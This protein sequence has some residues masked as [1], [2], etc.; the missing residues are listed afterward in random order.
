MIGLVDGNNF[1]VSCEQVFDPALAGKPV[2]VLS[3][4]DGCCISRSNEFKALGI[5]MGTPFFQLRPLIKKYG[6][7]FRS[8]NYE[9]Y[10]DMSRRMI[11]VLHEFV[12]DVEQ[13][14]I[15][16]AFIFPALSPEDDFFQFGSK[17]RQTLL[18]WTGIPSGVGFAATKTL[19]KIANHIG[20]K[21]PSGIFVM[22]GM[23]QKILEN[24]PVSEIWGVGRRLA[25][26][27]ERLGIRNAWQLACQDHTV[28]GK[29]F[30]SVLAKTILELQ[31]RPCFAISPDNE[32][33]QSISC[34][35]SFGK[36]VTEL[37]DLEESVAAYIAGAA[38]KLRREKQSASG[39]NV[40]FQLYPE[41]ISEPI[42]KQITSCT[43]T[44]TCATDDTSRMMS[45]VRPKLKDIFIPGRRYK[46]SGAVF[47]GL[48][49]NSDR[50]YDLFTPAA[51]QENSK[52]FK[53]VDMLNRKYGKGTVKIL[54]E[55]LTKPWQMKREHLS[56]SYTTDWGQLL[57][58]K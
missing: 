27:L 1:F 55:G 57:Q 15:D 44:F 36:P 39:V 49:S 24:V 20:K 21:S 41:D 37:K 32:L 52:V 34:S 14:S 22:P 8:S 26:Q 56:Q 33:S 38:E 25:P 2:A 17:I 35:R 29:K 28:M 12:P 58:V 31:G 19:A 4:N 46:K 53:T 47:F 48:E 6:L 45:R 42:S 5:A 16:E 10:G 13:Y 9:L 30:S 43:V 23:P 40:Y 11:A 3:N 54:G 18:Q 50:I 7:I 51:A